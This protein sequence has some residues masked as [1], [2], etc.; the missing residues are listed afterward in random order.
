MSK[1][2]ADDVVT[3]VA[4]KKNDF[5]ELL[6]N[7]MAA[8]ILVVTLRVLTKVCQANFTETVSGVLSN[9]CSRIF[10][11]S[12]LDFLTK[13]PFE[14]GAEKFKNKLYHEDKN[15][16]WSNLI[17]F[18]KKVIELLPSKARDELTTILQKINP[19]S[20]AIELSQDYKIDETIKNSAL[21]MLDELEEE[22]KKLDAKSKKVETHNK[23]E[24]IEEKPPEDFRE[25]SVIPTVQDLYDQKPYIRPCKIKDAYDSIEH[26]LDVQFRLLREDFIAPLREGLQEYLQG[27]RKYRNHDLRIYRN[28]KLIAPHV[29]KNKNNVGV[30]VSFGVIKNIKWR[31]SKRF[32]Y[33]G[34]LLLS[35][36]NFNTILFATVANRDEKDLEKG[37]VLIEPCQGSEITRDLYD[38]NFVMLES[39]IYF[40]PYLAVL[41][42]MKRMNERNFPME[43]YLVNADTSIRLPRYL[44]ENQ[45]L[46]HKNFRLPVG[47]N[48]IWPTAENLNLD[49]T[50]YNA[51]RCALTQEFAVIQGP[52]G[53]GKT[54]IALKIVETLLENLLHWRPHGPIVVVCLTNHALDQFLE[55]ILKYTKSIV[56]IGARSK[57]ETLKP[58]TLL[59]RR[60]TVERHERTDAWWLMYETKREYEDALCQIEKARLVVKYLKTP[61]A[62]VPL[63]LL[64]EYCYDVELTQFSTNEE[65][66]NWLIGIDLIPIAYNPPAPRQPEEPAE[67]IPEEQP[68]DDPNI[69]MDDELE[70]T[71]KF[72]VDNYNRPIYP[73][74]SIDAF[75]GRI[76][77]QII[78]YR[79][80]FTEM[81]VLP[82]DPTIEWEEDL[83]TLTTQR[84]SLQV[85][86]LLMGNSAFYR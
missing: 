74:Q 1:L 36:D 52:P 49:E 28:V 71:Y 50:Q 35:R 64:Q 67:I 56:R 22:I 46:K 38:L 60:K 61:N 85:I 57:N 16:F 80:S 45:T 12:L 19:I 47:E 24:K 79:N 10:L 14:D 48:Q 39:K 84:L 83:N 44:E 68:E 17:E 29:A 6:N 7:D 30:T 4:E 33:G 3:K 65:L 66:V 69:H 81:F 58:Y 9:A 40:E 75:I 26:Y 55:G 82:F 5:E 41:S 20:T 73:L 31:N 27:E 54:F 13:L 37:F 42:A 23:E 70:L 72:Q 76:H 2:I 78:E 8:D 43:N 21:A 34:L 51:F 86:T 53:T 11:K 59:E 63:H 15:G 32:M 77:Q 18:F 25:L 62:I